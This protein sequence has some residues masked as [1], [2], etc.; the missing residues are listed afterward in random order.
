MQSLLIS[1]NI[2]NFLSFSFCYT[3]STIQL[4]DFIPP[5][6]NTQKLLREESI[7]ILLSLN[8]TGY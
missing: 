4:F 6:L 5:S 3:L 8:F 1:R 2:L 7:F